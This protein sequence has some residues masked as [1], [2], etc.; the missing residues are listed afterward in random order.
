M[1]LSNTS[2]ASAGS[3]RGASNA[4]PGKDQQLMRLIIQ[5]LR[6]YRG[7]L[8]IVFIAMLVEIAMS[9][10]APWPLKLVLDDA[11]GHH[12]LPEW[13]AWAHGYGFGRGKSCVCGPGAIGTILG[14]TATIRQSST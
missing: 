11:L 2:T 1:S 5:L 12:K 10:A 6:P 3:A 13:L 14:M 8:L 9:L 4:S 7:W